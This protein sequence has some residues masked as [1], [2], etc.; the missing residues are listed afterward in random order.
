M[1]LL[2]YWRRRR[3]TRIYQNIAE[4]WMERDTSLPEDILPSTRVGT[5]AEPDSLSPDSLRARPRPRRL[6]KPGPDDHESLEVRMPTRY[7]LILVAAIGILLLVVAILSTVLAMQ[8][9]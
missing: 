2:A 1:G 5:E 4:H 7:V 9:C 8:S 3:G 6:R